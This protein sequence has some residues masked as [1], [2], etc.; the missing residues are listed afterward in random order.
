VKINT[1][2]EKQAFGW[3]YEMYGEYGLKTGHVLF[4]SF[5]LKYETS[6]RV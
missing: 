1:K 4:K 3:F 2:R 6:L 5:F